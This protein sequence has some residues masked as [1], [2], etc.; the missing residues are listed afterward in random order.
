MDLPIDLQTSSAAFSPSV[1]QYER[2]GRRGTSTGVDD[3]PPPAGR[4]FRKNSS[5]SLGTVNEIVSDD[6][7]SKH[8]KA[9]VEKHLAL[10]QIRVETSARLRELWIDAALSGEAFSEDSL[11]DLM[12]F[13]TGLT[14]RERPSLFLLDNGNLRA[15]WRNQSDEQVGLQF[16]GQEL[17]QYVMFARR[18]NSQ[19]MLHHY[20]QE[21]LGEIRTTITANGCDHLID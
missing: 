11:E 6:A 12:S 20:G 5:E 4:K 15:L 21:L 10:R 18:P 13:L 9:Q 8:F 19:R 3:V 16:M 14:P 2:P 1:A 7:V 17:V